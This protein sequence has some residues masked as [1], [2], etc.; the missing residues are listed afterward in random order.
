MGVCLSLGAGCQDPE[1]I[2]RFRATPVTNIILDEL[3]VVDEAPAVYAGA[4][5]VRPEDLQVEETEYVIGPGDVLDITIFELYVA[6]Q[7]WM[8]RKQVSETGRLTL[9]EVGTFRAAGQTEGELAETL[10]KLLSP[11]ILKEPTVTVVVSGARKKV[12]SVSGAVAYPGAFELTQGD[13]RILRAL[14]AAGGI[15]QENSDYAYVVRT[16]ELQAGGAPEGP[17]E[18]SG[19]TFPW[20]DGPAPWGAALPETPG[21]VKGPPK[22]ALAQPSAPPAQPQ[23]AGGP[24]EETPD[25]RREE[26]LESISPL[27]EMAY[28]VEL[29]QAARDIG[30]V[31]KGADLLA[32]AASETEADQ[33]TGG[34]RLRARR[35][36]GRFVLEPTGGGVSEPEAPAKVPEPT[37]PE[38]PAG[39]PTPPGAGTGWSPWGAGAPVQEV[40][41]VNL[42]HLRGGDWTQ[43]IVIRA[44]D[45]I[46]V[47]LNAT[48]IFSVMG[49]VARPG[50]YNLAGE[51]LTVKQAIAAA[52]PLAATAWL[53]RCEIIRRVGGNREVTHMVN[54]EKLFAGAAPDIFLKPNDIVNVGT[55]PVARFVAVARQSFRT[56]YG[57]GFVYDRNFAD[58]DFMH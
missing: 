41:R 14:A 8:G 4:R 27:S 3:G 7:E 6:G 47:P 43:N 31:G 12:Y 38:L 34:P 56:T 49:Q 45:D 54:L 1:G 46:Q 58:K 44:G 30:A 18:D 21:Q 23:P 50:A 13:F 28:P 25:Q 26:L 15:P 40:V 17:A 53:S 48:G 2:G 33:P 55:H 24:P 39:L 29:G 57:F 52:G 16:V 11:R 42:K 20:P 9:P 37:G 5:E 32:A 10:R 35:E 51:R 22:E 36:G 19:A